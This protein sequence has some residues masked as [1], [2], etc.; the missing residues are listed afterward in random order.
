MERSRLY[1]RSR[2]K[3]FKI[4]TYEGYPARFDLRKVMMWCTATLRKSG[5]RNYGASRKRASNVSLYISAKRWVNE[6]KN[7]K[8]SK[9]RERKRGEITDYMWW[10]GWSG[11]SIDSLRETGCFKR[12]VIEREKTTK[13][14]TIDLPLWTVRHIQT[15]STTKGTVS[16]VRIAALRCRVHHK[17]LV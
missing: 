7:H 11:R 12:V 17:K 4:S 15:R 14:Q 9:E 2:R 10:V 8:R 16:I 6:R 3:I 5:Q 13:I 1:L